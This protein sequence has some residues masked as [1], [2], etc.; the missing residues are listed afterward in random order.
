MY[1][2]GKNADA[3]AL[4]FGEEPARCPCEQGKLIINTY[5]QFGITN[6]RQSLLT[7][8]LLILYMRSYFIKFI[9]LM[10]VWKLESTFSSSVAFMVGVCVFCILEIRPDVEDS[11]LL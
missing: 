2:Q 11:F 9:N 5:S 8:D 3:L 4:Y 6:D 10:L 7:G 1:G